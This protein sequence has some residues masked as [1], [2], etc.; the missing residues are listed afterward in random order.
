MNLHI[1]CDRLIL[2]TGFLF[3]ACKDPKGKSNIADRKTE[4]NK[5]CNALKGCK[6]LT[7]LTTICECLADPEPVLFQ[8]ERKVASPEQAQSVIDQYFRQNPALHSEFHH[9]A[10]LGL[11]WYNLFYGPHGDVV[12]TVGPDGNIYHTACGV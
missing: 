11:G 4:E 10:A 3:V 5:A 9:S 7:C 12:Y 2:T 8:T 1:N 6:Q